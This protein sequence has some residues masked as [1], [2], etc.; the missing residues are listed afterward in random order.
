MV[1]SCMG[2]VDVVALVD[3]NGDFS[4]HL[5]PVVFPGD[6]SDGFGRTQMAYTRSVVVF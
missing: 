6:S 4:E 1:A 3:I 2:Y 5:W